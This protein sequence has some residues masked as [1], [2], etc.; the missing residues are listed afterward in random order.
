MLNFNSNGLLVPDNN[1]QSNISELESVFVIGIQSI[2]RK[3]LFDQYMTYST[4]LKKLANGDIFIQWIDGSFTTQK[5][6]PADI[7]LVTFLDYSVIDGLGDK[8]TDFKYPASQNIYGVD[9]YIVK[10][11]PQSHKFY[12]AF[13]ADRAYWLNHFSKARR[14]RIGNKLPKGFL[15]IKM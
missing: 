10:S 2:N 14:N 12:S 7:D 11:Y 15:E 3:Q 4:T 9:A 6:E 1:I 5:A 13:E 8:L